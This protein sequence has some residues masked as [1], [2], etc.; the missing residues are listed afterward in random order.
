[1]ALPPP[2]TI[3]RAQQGDRDAMDALIRDIRPVVLRQLGRYPLGEQDRADLLQSTLMQVVRRL[4]SFR[5]DASFSTWLFRVTANEALMLL[6][7]Q[8]RHRARLV[9]G[10]ESDQIDAITTDA[11]GFHEPISEDRHRAIRLRSALEDLPKT[12]QALIQAH[13]GQDLG[14]EEIA[15]RFKMTESAA[16]SRLHRARMRLRDVLAEPFAEAAA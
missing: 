11:F 1:M 6:R 12:Y 8:R 5:G 2:L 9:H 14:L 10:L 15:A 13:Y 7:T 16:R 4:D 3:E